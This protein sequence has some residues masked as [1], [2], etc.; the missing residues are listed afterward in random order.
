MIVLETQKKP[1]CMET[2]KIAA[3]CD[4]ICLLLKF[5]LHRIFCSRMLL[6]LEFPRLFPATIFFPLL[7]TCLFNSVEN[8]S[9]FSWGRNCPFWVLFRNAALLTNIKAALG[10][11]FCF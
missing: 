5:F 8:C 10:C 4:C 9:S 1:L 2:A 7:F 6:L 11:T 3:Y